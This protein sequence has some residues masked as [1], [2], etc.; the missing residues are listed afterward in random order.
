ML[1][2]CFLF[3]LAYILLI[4][5]VCVTLKRATQQIELDYPLI[6]PPCMNSL[7]GKP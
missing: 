1:G 4:M 7:P 3:A 5:A 2:I 6:E